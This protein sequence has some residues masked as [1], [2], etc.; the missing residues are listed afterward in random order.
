[1]ANKINKKKKMNNIVGAWR[2]VSGS[3]REVQ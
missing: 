1:M 3:K 2:A